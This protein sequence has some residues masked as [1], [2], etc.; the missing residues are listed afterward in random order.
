[1]TVTIYIVVVVG[2]ATGFAMIVELNPDEGLHAYVPPPLAF[3]FVE[4]PAQRVSF[5][6]AL[7]I[8]NALTVTIVLAVVVQPP[9]VT[10]T[11]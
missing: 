9:F 5:V 4:L 2:F 10:V 1:V 8:G 6:P 11:V 3:K 7:A